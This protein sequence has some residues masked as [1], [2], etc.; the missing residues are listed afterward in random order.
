M[1]ENTKIMLKEYFQQAR[2][3]CQFIT[4]KWD[5]SGNEYMVYFSTKDGDKIEYFEENLGW[6]LGDLI[7]KKLRL[8]NTGES[9]NNGE[10]EIFLSEENQL[11]IQFSAKTY[12][13]DYATE[14]R[15]LRLEDKHNLK[16]Y[17]PKAAISFSYQ[18]DGEGEPRF[19]LVTKARYG[20]EI[21]LDQSKKEYYEQ[22]F[23][24]IIATYQEEF[25]L[26]KLI[27][28]QLSSIDLSADL[29]ENGVLDI[30]VSKNYQVHNI[31]KDTIKTLID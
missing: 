3:S 19:H 24:P 11:C 26:T 17:L 8:T 29:T 13:Y 7:A 9:F 31:Y 30:T 20:D 14:Q 16:Q 12:Y 10:G 18:S 4:V 2:E 27:N 15:K 21:Y 22:Q 6:E 23:Q 25:V 28:K 5:A 1:K